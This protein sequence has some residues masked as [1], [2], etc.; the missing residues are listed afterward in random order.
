MFSQLWRVPQSIFILKNFYKTQQTYTLPFLKPIF[1]KIPNEIQ[2]LS[3]AEWRRIKDYPMLFVVLFVELFAELRQKPISDT[4]RARLTLFSASLAIYD[5]FFDNS[6]LDGE[7]I[8]E[9]YQNPQKI[10]F[11]SPQEKVFF[12]I[13]QVFYD[14]FPKNHLNF[15]NFQKKF[16]EF[17]Y[18]QQKSRLQLQKEKL[19]PELLREISF[20][21]GGTALLLSRLLMDN[22]PS[23]FEAKMVQDM[24]AWFQWFDDIVDIAQDMQKPSQTL[25]TN[26]THIQEARK[27]VLEV[28]KNVF[29]TMK[30]LDYP[31]KI[32]TKVIHQFFV[33]STSGWIH[34]SQL[35]KL[36]KTTNNI[37]QPQKY[38]HE[39]LLWRQNDWRNIWRAL[40]VWALF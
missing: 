8:L 11:Y 16:A 20:G 22:P 37:F 5:D 3:K 40:W 25:I 23:D 7:Y 15:Q 32:L 10:K 1:D 2:S 34:L 13:M 28:T 30:K 29:S 33:I 27:E 36:Q 31:P 19:N 4:E 6:D 18:F 24:G 17:W 35:E 12:E 9:I 26:T 14:Y 39:Q 21:K 38:T